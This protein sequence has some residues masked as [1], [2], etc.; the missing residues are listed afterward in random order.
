MLEHG[1]DINVFETCGRFELH[2]EI[3]SFL[4]EVLLIVRDLSNIEI[5][6]IIH[7]FLLSLGS[8]L[9]LVEVLRL[10]TRNFFILFTSVFDWGNG[11]FAVFFEVLSDVEE[12]HSSFLD[13]LLVVHIDFHVESQYL[14]RLKETLRLSLFVFKVMIRN[15]GGHTDSLLLKVFLLHLF[16]K[17]FK[18]SFKEFSLIIHD[19]ANWRVDLTVSEDKILL[20]GVSR[21]LCFSQGHFA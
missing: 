17:L 6:E 2:K 4:L 20:N 7:R 5:N 15:G 1:V 11:H 12:H 13:V 16:A 8:S 10:V 3:L 21:L 14:M 19:L 18:Q 9:H